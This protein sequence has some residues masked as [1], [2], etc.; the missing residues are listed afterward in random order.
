MRE[1]ERESKKVE[2]EDKLTTSRRRIVTLNAVAAAASIAIG[3]FR[4]GSVCVCVCRRVML[5]R[6]CGKLVSLAESATVAATAAAAAEELISSER[7]RKCSL[8]RQLP[9]C[10]LAPVFGGLLLMLIVR[11]AL[12]LSLS[13]RRVVMAI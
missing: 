2:D 9:V 1:R 6:R 11:S 3:V 10:S 7:A 5:I 4:C 12:S 8:V 13:P